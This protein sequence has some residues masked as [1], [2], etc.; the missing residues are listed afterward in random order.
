MIKKLGE[1]WIEGMSGSTKSVF[2]GTYVAK[3]GKRVHFGPSGSASGGA[4]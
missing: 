3:W 1:S 4:K 2:G